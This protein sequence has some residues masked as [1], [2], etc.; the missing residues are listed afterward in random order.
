MPKEENTKPVSQLIYQFFYFYVYEF[1]S[2]NMVINIKEAG[3]D[4]VSK[5]NSKY[6]NRGAG[7]T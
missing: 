3:S 1:D 6:L 5:Q 7:F 4:S 2:A